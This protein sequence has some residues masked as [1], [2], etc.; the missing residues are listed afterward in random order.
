MIHKSLSSYLV[1]PNI[2]PDRSADPTRFGLYLVRARNPLKPTITRLTLALFVWIYALFTGHAIISSINASSSSRNTL[3]KG[4]Q[5]TQ[6]TPVAPAT[7]A[8]AITKIKILSSD[9]TGYILPPE[10]MAPYATYANNYDQ[11]QCT[12]YVATRRNVP[13]NW[14]NADT[15]YGKAALE[16]WSVGS[17]PAVGA[18][19]WTPAGY[20]GHV[21][22]VEQISTDYSEVYVSEMNYVGAGIISHRWVNAS[23][24]KYIYN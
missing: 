1:Q 17:I 23:S 5:I 16:G 11:G 9:P 3:A 19:A 2:A 21:A 6:A 15:W 14:G 10:Y 20:Y 12:W 24:F 18:I 22:L 4:A 8:P 13:S 7:A